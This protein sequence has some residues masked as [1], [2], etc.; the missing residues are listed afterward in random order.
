MASPKLA[1]SHSFQLRDPKH[2]TRTN[3]LPGKRHWVPGPGKPTD[4]TSRGFLDA[5][6]SGEKLA[7]DAGQEAVQQRMEDR[8]AGPTFGGQLADLGATAARGILPAPIRPFVG[9]AVDVTST[10]IPAYMGGKALGVTPEDEAA[11]NQAYQQGLTPEQR[12]RFGAGT[13][14]R[15][16]L[17][18]TLQVGTT[19]NSGLK[20]PAGMNAGLQAFG[21]TG[22]GDA[23]RGL[24]GS[25]AAGHQAYQKAGGG[26]ANLPH[27]VETAGKEMWDKGAI[28]PTVTS[29]GSGLGTGYG[30]AK[31]LGSRA[32]QLGAPVGR[33]AS[34]LTPTAAE[35][36]TAALR[37]ATVAPGLA[38][39]LLGGSGVR[40]LP[41]A[42]AANAA[43]GNTSAV[44]GEYA[45]TL[46][47][48]EA[49]DQFSNDMTDRAAQYLRD[50]TPSALQQGGGAL[51]AA[52][53]APQSFLNQ[54]RA[55]LA[56]AGVY[57]ADTQ[58]AAADKAFTADNTAQYPQ[59]VQ[60]HLDAYRKTF[61][62][63]DFPDE[64]QYQR[65]TQTM[66]EIAAA[67]RSNAR[68]SNGRGV[69]LHTQGPNAFERHLSAGEIPGVQPGTPSAQL[70]QHLGKELGGGLTWNPRGGLLSDPTY[71]QAL[72][73]A[74]ARP[75]FNITPT[76]HLPVA[77]TAPAYKAPSVPVGVVPP[78]APQTGTA[79]APK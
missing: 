12:A 41:L 69:D 77:N 3:N 70:A 61:Q 47:S 38:R 18:Q 59:L 5:Y 57:G 9:P 22:G 42:L 7:A 67:Q 17:Q 40:A 75:D 54:Q 19:A 66:A 8:L 20:L 34:W 2:L 39:G 72:Q 21:A 50:G 25:I 52:V 55:Q 49:A 65:A 44:G 76:G 1:P 36:G 14:G 63:G 27:A 10:A 31:A 29:L 26:L 58:Q 23:L 13:P 15:D 60:Q 62:P 43:I 35:A 73:R 79:P 24:S 28:A 30:I 37:A 6:E 51:A 71:Q 33:A 11:A 45:R 56:N 74:A 68:W 4:D 48:P 64:A 32:A 78:A 53:G 16:A 46:G